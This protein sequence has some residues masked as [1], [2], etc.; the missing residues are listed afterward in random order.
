[1]LYSR[2][3][4]YAIRAMSY[5]AS[6][7]R[8]AYTPIREVAEATRVPLPF[9]AKIVQTLS[10]RGLL[11][12]QRGR[13]GGVALSSPPA[14]ILLEDIVHAVDGTDLSTM[15]VLGL[16]KCSDTA[17]CAVHDLWKGLRQSLLRTLHAKRLSEIAAA[18]PV[19]GRA[20]GETS[21]RR[22][23]RSTGKGPSGETTGEKR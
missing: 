16:A 8:T 9:L 10:R 1:M 20:M 5:L 21:V 13:G 2:S 6:Q 7:P 17:P 18:A 22:S 4:Q 15:C 19:R 12:S 11:S 14:D 23:R 3:T